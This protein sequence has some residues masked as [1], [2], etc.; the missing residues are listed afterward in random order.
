MDEAIREYQICFQQMKKKGDSSKKWNEKKGQKQAQGCKGFKSYNFKISYRNSQ[1]KNSGKSEKIFK[2]HNEMRPIERTSKSK[3]E[4]ATRPQLQCWG[5]IDTHSVKIF[6][7]QKE[8][9]QETHIQEASMVGEVARGLPIISE[10][11]N[12]H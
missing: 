11:L 9:S 10:T 12:G 7:Y 3:L 4:V 6:P 2:S 8:K 1:N 5:C